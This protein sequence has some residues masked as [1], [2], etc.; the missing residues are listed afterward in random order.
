MARGTMLGRCPLCGDRL[1]ERS[2]LAVRESDSW[3]TMFA[4][5]RACDAVVNP[6]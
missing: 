5:C 6:E 2:L 1:G 3:S 4:E